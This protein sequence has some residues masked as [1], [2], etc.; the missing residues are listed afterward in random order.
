MSAAP[1]T[2]A[3]RLQTL[4]ALPAAWTLPLPRSVTH[5]QDICMDD[6]W[7]A[8]FSFALVFVFIGISRSK[9]RPLSLGAK[10]AGSAAQGYMSTG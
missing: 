3:S 8:D 10:A 7:C 2:H 5:E 9:S 1:G 6:S 4:A